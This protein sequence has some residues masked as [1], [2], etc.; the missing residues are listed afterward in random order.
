MLPNQINDAPAAVALLDVCE[1]ER[2][3]LR[4]PQ[5]ATQQHGEDG[6]IR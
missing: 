6:A 1:C 3:H 2:R 5:P 4:S